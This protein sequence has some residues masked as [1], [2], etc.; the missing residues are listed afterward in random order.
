MYNIKVSISISIH[1]CPGVRYKELKKNVDQTFLLSRPY[2]NDKISQMIKGTVYLELAM[3]FGL[4]FFFDSIFI[5][6]Y[7]NEHK[8]S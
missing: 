2:L 3:S 6:H 8:W 4:H 5:I 7:A 1:V